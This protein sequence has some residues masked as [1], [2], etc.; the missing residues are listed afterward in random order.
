MVWLALSATLSS[1]C[2]ATSHA[3]SYPS[4]IRMGCIPRSSNVR[5]E[6][7]RAPARTEAISRAHFPNSK[8]ENT[9]QPPQSFHLQ[10]HH[11]GI[12]TPESL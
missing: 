8:V 7:S 12:L 4:A 5:A 9:H 10:S 1:S 2:T 3:F 11:P 6:D